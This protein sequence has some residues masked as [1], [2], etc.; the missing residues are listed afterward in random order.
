MYRVS[1]NHT[2]GALFIFPCHCVCV[3]GGARCGSRASG[4]FKYPT[5]P[6]FWLPCIHLAVYG[7]PKAPKAVFLGCE[8]DSIKCIL[9]RVLYSGLVKSSQVLLS[10][11]SLVV[12]CFSVALSLYNDSAPL[13]SPDL[14]CHLCAL[15][16]DF[17]T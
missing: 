11:G 15:S 13:S 16:Q 17:R 9:V 6:W 1:T 8:L 12:A 2:R 4:A 3:K 14:P 7:H 10:L 5:H